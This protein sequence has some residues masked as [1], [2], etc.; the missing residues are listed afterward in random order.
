MQI[1]IT[2]STSKAGYISE[3][4]TTQ[5]T[6]DKM[7]QNFPQDESKTKLYPQVTNKIEA[8]TLKRCLNCRGLLMSRKK[9]K[10]KERNLPP[11]KKATNSEDTGF[12]YLV[13][14]EFPERIPSPPSRQI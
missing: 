3:E 11:Q 10:K 5:L 13:I 14:E 8:V 6:T 9:E 7:E 4:L 12:P 2:Y 1:L